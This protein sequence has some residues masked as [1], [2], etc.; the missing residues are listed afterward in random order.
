MLPINQTDKFEPEAKGIRQ[1]PRVEF[2][3]RIEN[4]RAAM[5]QWNVDLMLLDDSEAL[6]YF[7]GYET[8]LNRYRAV[9]VP[10]ANDPIMVLRDLDVAPFLG[11][12]WFNDHVG[13][14]D[15]EDVINV[16]ATVIR[17]RGF[18]KA[19]IGID[20]GSHAMTIEYYERLRNALPEAHFINMLHVPWEL[21]L[22]KSSV[23]IECI[24]RAAAIADSTLTQIVKTVK[25]GMTERQIASLTASQ[26]IAMGGDPGLIGPITVGHGWGFLHGPLHDDPLTDG[27][28]LHLELTPRYAGYSARLMRSI[29][30]GQPNN[31]QY[32]AAE[33]LASLQDQQI[34][35]MQ[36]G[37]MAK[38]VDAILREGVVDAGLRDSYSNITGYVLG[39]YPTKFLR[40]SDFT[41]TFNPKAEWKL[42]AGMVFHMYASAV[43]LAFSETVA[44]GTGGPNRLTRSD[45]RIYS[46]LDRNS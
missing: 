15:T 37:A 33:T 28:V 23:E 20:H 10:L 43:G 6:G 29:V 17:Q 31:E 27:D 7:A 34:A 1:F 2:V 44:V 14:A 42:E 8:S 32:K 3:R 21:R 16:I 38:D 41:R 12:A 45:R 19:R 40:S 26:F 13:V 22:I 18:G 30:I 11:Q 35:A 5:R 24:M 25:P 9:L 46:T 39:Y 36:A 4:L